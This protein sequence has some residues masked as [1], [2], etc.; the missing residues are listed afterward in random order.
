MTSHW[1]KFEVDAAIEDYFDM[2]RLEL[3]CQKYNKAKHRPIGV[4]YLEV[5]ARNRLLGDAGEQFAINFERARLIHAGKES[6]ADK[7]EQ[8]S[9][10]VGP[11]AGFDIRSFETNGTDRLIEAKTTKYGKSTPFYSYCE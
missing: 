2:L 7:I 3:S 5:E 8:V 4:N 1:S 10:S 6:L 9:V 11:S